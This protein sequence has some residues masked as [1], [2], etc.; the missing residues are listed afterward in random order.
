MPSEVHG[1]S[2]VNRILNED[3]KGRALEECKQFPSVILDEEHVKDVKNIA[4]GVYSPLDGFLCKQDLNSVIEHMRLK[5]NVIWPI[6]IVLDVSKDKA[7]GLKEGKKVSLTD[8]DSNPIAILE[9]EEKFTF[10][11]DK[12]AKKVFLTNDQTHPGV[13]SL[14][15]RGEVFLGGKID[16]IDNTKEPFYNRN[17]DPKE[18]RFLFNKKGWKRVVAF[19]TRNVPHLGHEYL[20]RC[21]LEIADGL[22]INPVIGRKKPGDFKDEIILKAYEILMENYYPKDKVVL[23]ILPMQMR[24]AGP[25]EAVFHAIVRKNFGCTHFIVG[26]D[27]AGVGNFYGHYDSQDIFN[28]I[29]KELGIEALRFENSF[30]CKKCSSMATSKTCNHEKSFKLSLSGTKLREVISTG[31]ELEDNFMR[32]EVINFLKKSPKPYV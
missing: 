17:L 18:T 20:Q 24:Y 6:P 3:Q 23:S 15:E 31:Q 5:N 32:P 16:L 26:R 2:L 19:Q 14:H 9:L 29:E 28:N 11:K 21:G 1:G 12:I 10:D 27:H 25:R 7:N 13:K 30:Y 22:F 8:K 4:R